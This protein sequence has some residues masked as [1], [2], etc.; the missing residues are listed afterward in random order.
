MASRLLST[1]PTMSSADVIQSVLA[2]A[3][4][5]SSSIHYLWSL[6]LW[7]TA[8]VYVITIAFVAMSVMRGRRNQRPA[9]ARAESPALTG[10]VAAAVAL[11]V[12]IL[13]GLLVA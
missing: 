6:M 2:P 9:D 10:S 11:T 13:L 1:L 12:V 7:V 8:G 5:Q 4:I 3:G